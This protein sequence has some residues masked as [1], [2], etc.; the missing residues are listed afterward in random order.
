MINKIPTYKEYVQEK[1]Q[2]WK[3]HQ[4]LLSQISK[5]IMFVELFYK[6]NGVF[7]N[8]PGTIILYKNEESGLEKLKEKL[9]QDFSE[10][11]SDVE[12][13]SYNSSPIYI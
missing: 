3:E 11:Y 2:Y 10:Q 13:Y 1:K 7:F 12:F 4:E 6:T 8:L 9:L 5:K